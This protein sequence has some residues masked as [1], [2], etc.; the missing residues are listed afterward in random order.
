MANLFLF[1]LGYF[2][3]ALHREY[4]ARFIH[5]AGTVR[6]PEKAAAKPRKNFGDAE[7]PP[8]RGSI[9]SAGIEFE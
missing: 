6:T 8:V 7:S 1:R 9:A 3:D 5:I 4:G 2:G